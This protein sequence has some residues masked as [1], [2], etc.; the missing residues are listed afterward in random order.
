MTQADRSAPIR[1]DP[2]Y[3]EVIPTDRG[4]A[5]A[6]NGQVLRTGDG[7]VEVRHQATTLLENII[8]EFD[9]QGRI[10][11][12]GQVIVGP[13]FFGSFALFSVQKSWI[14]P[15]KDDLTLDFERRLLADPVLHPVP[16]PEKVD[17]YARW[18]SIAEWLG[19]NL[20]SLRALA[21]RIPH[22]AGEEEL[23]NG[24][25]ALS[26]A[27][28]DESLIA[29]RATYAAM[30]P[31]ERAVVMMLYSLHEGPVLLPMA[32]VMGRCTESEYARGVMAGHAMLSS[33]F[34]DVD[35]SSHQEAFE[36]LRSDA[37][38]GL[39][40]VRLYRAGTPNERLSKLITSGENT[41]QEFKS[42]LRW[43]IRAGKM[44]PEITHACIKTIA[45]F[46]NSEGG[47]L[48]IGVADD[49]GIVGIE[50]D[51]FANA[52]KF[53]LHLINEVKRQLG[54]PSASCLHAEVLE[55]AENSIC[56]VECRRSPRPVY[57]DTKEGEK[58]FIRTGPSTTALAPRMMVD[59]VHHHFGSTATG[60]D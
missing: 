46:L 45:A 53:L 42:T 37:R 52:D 4:F 59:Y 34:V 39:D 5:L 15:E 17:Q 11:I 33:V 10:E 47:N 27:C 22:W 3:L 51:G 16:G 32:L 40:Y 35:E 56:I 36:R 24:G 1:V 26:H 25:D 48:L 12:A 38:T 49:G 13:R 50:Q 9:G 58:F 43:N 18:S 30:K 7:D 60:S 44:D 57:C 31:E 6:H 19:D 41:K 29:L 23:E 54:A 21:R 2:T 14:E 20:G 55:L 8:S 28:E